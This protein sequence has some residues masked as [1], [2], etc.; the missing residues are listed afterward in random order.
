MRF[1]NTAGPVEAEIHYCLPPLHRWNLD[2]VL[3]LIGQR[4]YFV[5][6]A[7]R[8]T[9]KTSCIMALAKYLNES[10]RYRAVYANIE[11]AQACR[12]DVTRGMR[13][14]VQSI[15]GWAEALL[16]DRSAM[17]FAGSVLAEVEPAAALERFL[18][19]WSEQ[20]DRPMVL[21]L[22]EVDALIGDTLISLLRQLRSGYPLRPDRFPQSIILCGV[23]DVRDYRIHSSAEKSIITGG[24][25]F[26][27]RAESLRLGDFSRED[28]EQLYAQHTAETGQVFEPGALDA[29][30]DLSSGQP[31]VVN[32]LAYDA[33]FRM[34]EG[35]DR[36]QSVTA[37]MMQQA[38]EN[39]ILRRETHLDQLADKLREPRV[40]RVIE[41]L[42]TGDV[43]A[44]Q[45]K[46][47]DVQ[48]VRDLGLVSASVEVCIANGIY[49]EVIPR[50]LTY[51]T[52]VMMHQEPERYIQPDGRLDMVKLIAAFQEFFREH[53][54]HWMGRFDYL[55]AG[56]QLLMQAFLQSIMNG[57]G[58]IHREYG[59]GRGRTD[60][61]VKW[62]VRPGEPGKEAPAPPVQRS[63][64]ELKVIGGPRWKGSLDT[65]IREGVR[66][67]AEYL[68]RT[69]TAE[70]H[71]II[72]DRSPEKSW[73]EKIW[74][75]EEQIEGKT[76]TV[77]GM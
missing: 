6:H 12:E 58:Q 50:E 9:G 67:T 15:A 66:Q 77:W 54:E 74:R 31:W 63:V 60:L 65:T 71:L 11:S 64:I 7:P 45:L 46:P 25:A 59:L 47:D 72:F 8:Q 42:L 19:R 3:A 38:S 52:Q 22:D 33:C 30:W 34:D 55:E 35:K 57:G 2:D 56:P 32:A 61:L 44:D 27:I 49:R 51:D 43:P 17:A 37:D 14:V 1:F 24:S 4:K 36:S 62:P 39:L 5:L 68:D 29:A 75:R 73:E 70:G 48:Y 69:S 10:G 13:T 16:D 40:R 76:I 21:M 20:C 18:A 28:M 26:N 23:R 53:S 41:P